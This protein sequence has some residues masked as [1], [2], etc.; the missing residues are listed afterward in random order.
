MLDMLILP[1]IGRNFTKAIYFRKR[2]VI[3]IIIIIII[4]Q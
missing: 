3:I 1:H 2:G 4:I